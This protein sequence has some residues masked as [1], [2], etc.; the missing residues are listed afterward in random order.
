MPYLRIPRGTGHHTEPHLSLNQPTFWGFGPSWGVPQSFKAHRGLCPTF[1]PY[2]L[3]QSEAVVGPA[4]SKSQNMPP[5]MVGPSVGPHIYGSPAL[6]H[7]PMRI[8]KWSPRGSNG[9]AQVVG[10]APSRRPQATVWWCLALAASATSSSCGCGVQHCGCHQLF[11]G[12]FNC[13]QCMGLCG[14]HTLWGFMVVCCMYDT[15]WGY[16]VLYHSMVLMVLC[17]VHSQVIR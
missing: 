3:T 13:S 11:T 10:W 9:G 1:S 2:D 4:R 5:A 7:V 15:L 17:G 8:S 14:P 16:M 12:T 6:L